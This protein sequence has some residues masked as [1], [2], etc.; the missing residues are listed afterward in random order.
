VLAHVFLAGERDHEAIAGVAAE[1][2]TRIV[3]DHATGLDVVHETCPVV[4]AFAGDEVVSI[5]V[6]LAV[7]VQSQ[8]VL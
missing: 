3:A 8:G 2:G 5:W 6:A 1:D 4:V 7:V